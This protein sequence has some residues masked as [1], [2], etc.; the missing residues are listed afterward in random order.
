MVDL[1]LWRTF[2]HTK[3]RESRY[4]VT[5]AAARR[6]GV[7]VL[8][9]KRKVR[10]SVPFV[11]ASRRTESPDQVEAAQRGESGVAGDECAGERGVSVVSSV[12][13]AAGC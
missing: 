7:R 13:E 6:T 9:V 1:A 10:C 3:T 12:D 5:A 4:A 2:C 8:M 11:S